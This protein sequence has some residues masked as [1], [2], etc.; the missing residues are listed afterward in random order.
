MQSFALRP[1]PAGRDWQ[2]Y[3]NECGR[4]KFGN[5]QIATNQVIASNASLL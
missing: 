2:L 4:M 5:V 3:G 1:L